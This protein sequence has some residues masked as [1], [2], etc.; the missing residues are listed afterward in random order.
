MTELTLKTLEQQK[1]ICYF[2][3]KQ[4]RD[5]TMPPHKRKR[6]TDKA[7]HRCWRSVLPWC[8]AHA[9]EL[10]KPCHDHAEGYEKKNFTV[11]ITITQCPVNMQRVSMQFKKQISIPYLNIAGLWMPCKCSLWKPVLPKSKLK[12]ESEL[13]WGMRWSKTGR[14]W[15]M[16]TWRM[17]WLEW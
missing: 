13:N 4:T 10:F 15:H 11:P 17:T 1:F 7:V 14:I 8:N 5:V 6:K 3:R 16:V 12:G 2:T 9:V